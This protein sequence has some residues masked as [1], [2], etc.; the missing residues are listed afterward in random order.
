MS[1]N[2]SRSGTKMAIK[3]VAEEDVR[4]QHL[5]KEEGGTE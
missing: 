2:K 5:N 1:L 3:K 4:I